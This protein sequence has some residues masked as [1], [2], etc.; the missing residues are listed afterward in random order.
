MNE[1]ILT[2]IKFGIVGFS[3][4]VLDFG[5][6]YLL[7]EKLKVNKFLANSLGFSIAVINN[8][9][10]NRYWTF[11]SDNLNYVQEFS[12]FIII[13]LVGLAINNLV[14]YFFNEKCKL[15]FY[16]SKLLAIGVVMIWNFLM[17]YFITFSY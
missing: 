9:L 13:S 12:L 8:Y 3:G 11:E 14:L 17:N 15:G 1:F 16:I 6:T 4:F 10:L 7:K 5:I 2:F